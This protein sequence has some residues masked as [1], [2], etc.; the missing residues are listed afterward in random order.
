M[1]SLKHIWIAIL[2]MILAT[3]GFALAFISPETF[4]SEINIQIFLYVY[5]AL[6]YVFILGVFMVVTFPDAADAQRFSFGH[7]IVIIGFFVASLPISTDLIFA[8]KSLSPLMYFLGLGVM[9]YGILRANKK[10]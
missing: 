10:D 8:I 5:T 3:I 9:L 7:S 1:L 6:F 2:P 4:S